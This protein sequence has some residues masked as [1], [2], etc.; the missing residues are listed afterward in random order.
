M[1]SPWIKGVQQS[2]RLTVFAGPGFLSA[3]AWGAGLF[4]QILDEFNRLALTNRFDVRLIASATTPLPN[5][6]GA[7][8]QLE[9]T[10]GKLAYFDVDG[11]WQTDT[12][13]VSPG[14]IRGRTYLTGFG[15]SGTLK[16]ARAFIFVPINPTLGI[17]QRGVGKG[18]KMALTLHELLHA[19]GLDNS[20]PGHAPGSTPNDLFTTDTILQPGNKPDE[21][22]MFLGGK[23]Q[24]DA[25]G[26]FVLT[27][28]TIRLVQSVWLLGQF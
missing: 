23:F 18:P 17:G 10:N 4:K 14:H 13:D 25:S 20:D 3:P 2:G 6:G 24:P 19:C 11:S 15:Q 1:P 5:G 26:H 12:L 28:T 22:K 7:N 27:P 21:D 9:V 8:V 16:I